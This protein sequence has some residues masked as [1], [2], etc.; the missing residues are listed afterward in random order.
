MWRWLES[1]LGYEHVR[2]VWER[3][4]DELA[5]RDEFRARDKLIYDGSVQGPRADLGST[6]GA[7]G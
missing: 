4:D 5:K 3:R 1:T 7:A 6:S 2:P